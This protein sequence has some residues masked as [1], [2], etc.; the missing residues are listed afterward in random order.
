M[1]ALQ[2]R[3]FNVQLKHDPTESGGFSDDHGFVRLIGDGNVLAENAT[4]QHNRNF[5]NRSSV[6]Q[7][8]AEAALSFFEKDVDASQ[9]A[10]SKVAASS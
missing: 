2:S 6:A 10:T 1:T 4:F 9:N 7:E 3:N 8:L 5:S